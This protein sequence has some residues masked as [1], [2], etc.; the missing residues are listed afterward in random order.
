MRTFLCHV[1]TMCTQ[2]DAPI[3][4][5]IPNVRDLNTAQPITVRGAC[6]F[7]LKAAAGSETGDAESFGAK[8]SFRLIHLVPKELRVRFTLS[9]RNG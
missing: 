5:H 4:V 7:G 8:L 6:G 1:I 9:Q 2:E 3:T